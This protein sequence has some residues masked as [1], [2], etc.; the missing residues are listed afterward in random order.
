MCVMTIITSYTQKD[1]LRTFLVVVIASSLFLITSLIN[2][3]GQIS[4][5]QY[6]FAQKNTALLTDN[7][8]NSNNTPKI[9]RCKN[10]FSRT[11]SKWRS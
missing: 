9:P 3:I 11:W 7:K 2:P 8:T 10:S 5:Q 1:Q 6:V 4:Q